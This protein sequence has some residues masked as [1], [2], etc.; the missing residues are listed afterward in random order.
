[1][2]HTRHYGDGPGA[3]REAINEL[4]WYIGKKGAKALIRAIESN[5]YTDDQ[6]FFHASFAGVTG[7]PVGALIRHVQGKVNA[8]KVAPAASTEEVKV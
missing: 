5:E 6:I 8:V 3:P 1:M 7:F 2:G 4:I